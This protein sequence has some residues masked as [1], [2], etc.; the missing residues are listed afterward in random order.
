MQVNRDLIEIV[1][2][3][4]PAAFSDDPLDVRLV[5]ALFEANACA[6]DQ[7]RV[8][9]GEAPIKPLDLYPIYLTSTT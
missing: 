5:R 2:R 7:Q 3:W 4:C 6:M 9:K 8:L 1:D